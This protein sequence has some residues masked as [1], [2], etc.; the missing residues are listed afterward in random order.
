M[1]MAESSIAKQ[2]V[3]RSFVVTVYRKTGLSIGIA[4]SVAAMSLSFVLSQ[5]VPETANSINKS[6]DELPETDLTRFDFFYAGEGKF[7]NMFIV[8]SGEIAWEFKG[9]RDQGEIRRISL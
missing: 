1:R 7:Q 3:L 2:G 5:T 6:N 9:P 8:K 4:L